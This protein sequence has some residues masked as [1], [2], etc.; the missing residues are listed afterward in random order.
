M[1]CGCTDVRILAF[2]YKRASRL[3]LAPFGKELTI[4]LVGSKVRRI[5][6]IGG[7]LTMQVPATERRN[8]RFGSFEVDLISCELR[9]DGRKIKLQEQPFQILA[10]LLDQPGE[11]VTREEFRQKLWPSDTFVDFEQGINTRLRSCARRWR[12]MPMSRATSRPCRSTGTGSSLLW[13]RSPWQ[14]QGLYRAPGSG[15]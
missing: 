12:T 15:L 1:D 13:Q 11:L 7:L 6:K 2:W 4:P 14:K 3:C 9:K 8:V 5:K 10:I